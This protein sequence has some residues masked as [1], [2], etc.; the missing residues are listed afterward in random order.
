ME[1]GCV[2]K[3]VGGGGGGAKING[4]QSFMEAMKI[5]K[6]K[7]TTTCVFIYEEPER[8]CLSIF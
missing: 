5:A 7:G 1:V 8:V 6:A 2:L 3:A 4:V